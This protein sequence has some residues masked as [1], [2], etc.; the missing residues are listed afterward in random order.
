MLIETTYKFTGTM[1]DYDGNIRNPDDDVVVV[2]I[3][4][5]NGTVIKTAAGVKV[6]DGVYQYEY[7]PAS[8]DIPVKVLF[9]G[10]YSGKA[11]ADSVEFTPRRL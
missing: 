5:H 11:V 1:T 9:S 8:I 3:Y 6:M 10:T 7:S 2:K 4:N